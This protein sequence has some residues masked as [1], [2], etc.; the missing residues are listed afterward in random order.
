MKALTQNAF[1]RQ[2]RDLERRRASGDIPAAEFE[3]IVEDFDWRQL[4]QV[5]DHLMSEWKTE[6]V[7]LLEDFA[8]LENLQDFRLHWCRSEDITNEE[9]LKTRD[10]LREIWKAVVNGEQVGGEQIIA[11]WEAYPY[12]NDRAWHVWPLTGRI[13]PKF[14]VRGRLALILA[15]KWE[16]LG[17]CCN[18]PLCSRLYVKS[19]TDQ[20]YCAQAGCRAFGNRE[21]VTRH[22]QKK[23]RPSRANKAG[24]LRM[25]KR[26]TAIKKSPKR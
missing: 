1:R 13:V 3:Q 18:R 9:L 8:N 21:R 20:K 5:A 26:K 19:R 11:W 14:H 15:E 7:E 17:E 16:M 10:E 22:W 2:L 24:A 4:Q 6:H 25:G 12:G 23:G